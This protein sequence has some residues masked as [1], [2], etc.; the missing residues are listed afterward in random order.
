MI[1][2]TCTVVVLPAFAGEAFVKIPSLFE[3][4]AEPIFSQ[5]GAN[6]TGCR[7]LRTLGVNERQDLAAQPGF[8]LDCV[9]YGG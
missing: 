9:S 2:M 1:G 4:L 6:D 7:H 5:L 3:V 8:T